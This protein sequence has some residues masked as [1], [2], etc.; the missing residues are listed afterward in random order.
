[1]FL[2]YIYLNQILYQWENNSW[3]ISQPPV[4]GCTLCCG[5]ARKRRLQG[6]QKSQTIVVGDQ[7][8]WD[9]SGSTLL[10]RSRRLHAESSLKSGKGLSRRGMKIC[11]SLL[12]KLL[13]HFR[14]LWSHYKGLKGG[15]YW[16]DSLFL[17]T[18]SQ[19]FIWDAATSL[20]QRQIVWTPCVFLAPESR[21]FSDENKLQSTME[22]GSEVTLLLA[23]LE[24]DTLN[25]FNNLIL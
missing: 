21:I 20:N 14:D 7:R 12:Y 1:M 16:E 3:G 6:C 18:L 11:L 24:P 19:V 23:K 22:K 15:K 17:S 10:Y 4:K 25:N 13:L 5:W 2:V 9:S 8:V